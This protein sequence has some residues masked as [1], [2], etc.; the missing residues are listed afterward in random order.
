MPWYVGAMLHTSI[1]CCH[2]AAGLLPMA[3][4]HLGHCMH[5]LALTRLNLSHCC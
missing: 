2:A 1:A 3:R 4:A 5:K